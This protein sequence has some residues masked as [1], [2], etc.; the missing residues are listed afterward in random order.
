MNKCGIQY[1]QNGVVYSS[2]NRWTTTTCNNLE[3]IFQIYYW[4]EE[5]RYKWGYTLCHL[6][7]VHKQASLVY[8][9]KSRRV[10]GGWWQK[11]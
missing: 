4:V 8:D 3:K 5:S 11:G 7:K 9:V 1:L 6:Y 2:E 10:F